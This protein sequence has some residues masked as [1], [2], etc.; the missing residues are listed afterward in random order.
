MRYGRRGKMV[1]LPTKSCGISDEK[2]LKIMRR[3][4]HL[5]R[6][7]LLPRS[8]YISSSFLPIDEGE[9]VS[10]APGSSPGVPATPSLTHGPGGGSVPH[11]LPLLVLLLRLRLDPGVDLAVGVVELAVVENLA[12]RGESW[13]EWCLAVRAEL[14][15]GF[16]FELHSVGTD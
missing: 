14:Q 16:S 13:I 1:K 3:G 12:E 2:I 11:V 5:I 6:F 8:R 10:V 15:K 4:S 9:G 7:V